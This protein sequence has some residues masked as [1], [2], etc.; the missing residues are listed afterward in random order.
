M[1]YGSR[2]MSDVRCLMW[3]VR[4]LMCDVL[5]GKFICFSGLFNKMKSGNFV[6][7]RFVPLLDVEEL[8][9]QLKAEVQF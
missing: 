8:G 7:F 3:Y 2:L 1:R 5:C 6:K 9:K 4:R